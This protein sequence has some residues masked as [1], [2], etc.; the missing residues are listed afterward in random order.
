[1]ARYAYERLSAQDND[2]L[3]WERPGLPMHVAAT[4]I[5]R[6]GPLARPEGGIDFEA[7]RRATERVLHRVPRYRQ[8]LHGIP[9]ARKAVW[10]DDPRFN[11]DYNVRHTALPR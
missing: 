5:F 7:I 10:V 1:M 2:F 11:L 6:A 8:K 3:R 4:Q 9:G